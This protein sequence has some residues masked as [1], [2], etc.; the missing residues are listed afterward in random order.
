MFNEFRENWREAVRL[1]FFTASV[2]PVILGAVIAGERAGVFHWGYFILTFIAGVALHAG[3]NLGNDYFNPVSRTD[4][5]NV[6]SSRRS[7]SRA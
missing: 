2:V 5:N 6:Q 4:E 1:P 7:P 3:T